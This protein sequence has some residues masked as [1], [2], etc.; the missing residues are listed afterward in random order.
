LHRIGILLTASL[1]IYMSAGEP[2][3]PCCERLPAAA[4]LGRHGD[5]LLRIQDH[6]EADAHQRLVVRDHDAEALRAHGHPPSS[7]S[8]AR[9]A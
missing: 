3:A 5:V 4:R 8:H 1:G 2:A 7:G 9:A 6:A